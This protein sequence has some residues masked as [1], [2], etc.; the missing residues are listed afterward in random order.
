V[1]I[2]V[3]TFKLGDVEDPD[4]YA[5]EP[6]VQFEQSPKGKWVLENSTDI[7]VWSRSVDGLGWGWTYKI[8]A[9]LKESALT[10]WLLRYGDDA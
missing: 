1:K 3:H 6:L 8:T 2:V 9:D 4:L 10:E 5:A 7:P